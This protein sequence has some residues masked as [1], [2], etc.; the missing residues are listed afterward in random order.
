[1]RITEAKNV[2]FNVLQGRQEASRHIELRGVPVDYNSNILAKLPT[3]KPITEELLR[4]NGGIV[5]H[6]KDG[7]VVFYTE[8]RTPE[9]EL[10]FEPILVV[11]FRSQA[12][13]TS[14]ELD[15]TN[16]MIKYM[17]GVVGTGSECKSNGSH[18]RAAALDG[19]KRA[20][21]LSDMACGSTDTRA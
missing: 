13:M 17:N 16:V 6:A 5:H 18:A 8:A 19:S 1:M 9:G 14:E 4:S 12:Q 21:N 2:A 20:L 10:V 15:E 7:H 11:R 3:D